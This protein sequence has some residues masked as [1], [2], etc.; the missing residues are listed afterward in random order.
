MKKTERNYSKLIK[1]SGEKG[2]SD[3]EKRKMFFLGF[4]IILI[5]G[6]RVFYHLPGNKEQKRQTLTYYFASLFFWI[7]MITLTFLIIDNYSL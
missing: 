2:L 4:F 7:F 3:S 6:T 1:D 5:T